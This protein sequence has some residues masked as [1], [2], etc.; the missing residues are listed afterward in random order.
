MIEAV[1]VPPEPMT[2]LTLT[3]IDVCRCEGPIVRPL[4]H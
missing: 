2:T 3:R 4:E 1:K